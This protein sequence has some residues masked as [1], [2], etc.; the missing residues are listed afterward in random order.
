MSDFAK[1]L[2]ALQRAGDAMAARQMEDRFR[3]DAVR[4][5]MAELLARIEGVDLPE[6]WAMLKRRER[7]IYDQWLT[8]LEKVNPAAA[9][10]LDLRLVE[11]VP[12]DDDSGDVEKRG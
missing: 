5:I 10:M 3:L 4:T 12:T 6:A 2:A 11:D 1:E 8:E 7:E 9:A